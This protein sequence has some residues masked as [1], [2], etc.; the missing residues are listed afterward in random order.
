MLIV[1]DLPT[2]ISSGEM[3]MSLKISGAGK[4]GV[5]NTGVGFRFAAIVDGVLVGT[6]GDDEGMFVIIVVDGLV[7]GIDGLPLA[8]LI[9]QIVRSGQ[10][11][12]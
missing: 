5:V 12:L 2:K 7:V 9:P 10:F 1:I 8:R 4:E 6:I 11:A 3:F